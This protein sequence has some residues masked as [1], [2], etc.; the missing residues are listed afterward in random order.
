MRSV[1]GLLVSLATSFAAAGIGGLF[2]RSSVSTWYQSLAKPAFAPPDWIFGPVW[3]ALYFLMAV[4]AWLTWRRGGRRAAVGLTLFGGQ[5]ALNAA[6][7]GI[8]FGLRLPGWA[9]AE[10]VVLWVA[11]AATLA[12]FARVSAVAGLLLVP[13]LLWVTFAGL[14]N[15]TIWRLNA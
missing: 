3:T 14:L 10:L 7:S 15:F 4:A 11:I 9:L 6:W 2:T 5:L 13:Y 12:A 1:L 8:F